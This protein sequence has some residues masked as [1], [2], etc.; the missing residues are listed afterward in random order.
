ME[1][2]SPHPS[3]C[4]TL[5]RYFYPEAERSPED[6][7]QQ[8]HRAAD[9]LQWA[10][11]PELFPYQR[12]ALL[13]LVSDLVAGLATSPSVAFEQSFLVTALNSGLFQIAAA[14]FHIFCYSEGALNQRAWRKRQAEAYLFTRGHLLFD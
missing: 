10:V 7:A 3:T 2:C 12:D 1:D 6:L 9:V 14:E 11:T 8:L 5:T 13:C 4:I